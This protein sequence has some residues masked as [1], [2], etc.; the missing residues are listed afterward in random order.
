MDELDFTNWKSSVTELN[1][2]ADDIIAGKTDVYDWMSNQIKEAF[3][4]AGNPVPQVFMTNR[5][6]EIHCTWGDK[7]KLHITK[8]L[9]DNLMMEFDFNRRIDDDGT[10]IKEVTFYPFGRSED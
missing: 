7:I 9:V 6:A 4:E 8:S 2:K 5:G 10:W 3:K 1:S